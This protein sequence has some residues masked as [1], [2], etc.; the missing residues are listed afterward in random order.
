MAGH[1]NDEDLKEA[2]EGISPLLRPHRSG[3]RTRRLERK[4]RRERRR[5]FLAVGFVLLEL[6]GFFFANFAEKNSWSELGGFLLL[7]PAQILLNLIDGQFQLTRGLRDSDAVLLVTLLSLP[8]NVL[9]WYR[10]GRGWRWLRRRQRQRRYAP[11]GTHGP[12]LPVRRG[13]SRAAASSR[14][15][16]SITS[17]EPQPASPEATPEG[18]VSLRE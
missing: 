6:T 4:R 10:V 11:G 3:S 16:D 12:A 1:A 2:K 9:F 14:T 15:G 7:Q 8:L 18:A 13:T 17:R 5:I